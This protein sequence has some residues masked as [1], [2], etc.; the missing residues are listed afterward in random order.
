[1]GETDMEELLRKLPQIVQHLRR[2]FAASVGSH[3]H[4]NDCVEQLV[5]LL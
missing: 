2:Q 1:M 3:V 4:L 5:D